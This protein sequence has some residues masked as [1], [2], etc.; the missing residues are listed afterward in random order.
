MNSVT[1]RNKLK[2]ESDSQTSSYRTSNNKYNAIKLEYNR[3][4]VSTS[5]INTTFS[6]PKKST[7]KQEY[8]TQSSASDSL[9]RKYNVTQPK[10][11]HYTSSIRS[12]N[13][14]TTVS[15]PG[16]ITNNNVYSYYQGNSKLLFGISSALILFFIFTVFLLA[17][18]FHKKKR[19][20]NNDKKRIHD[21]SNRNNR[22][23]LDELGELVDVISRRQTEKVTTDDVIKVVQGEKFYLASLPISCDVRCNEAVKTENKILVN[24]IPDVKQVI[25]HVTSAASSHDDRAENNLE[26]MT[27]LPTSCDVHNSDV[28]VMESPSKSL[29]KSSTRSLVVDDSSFWIHVSDLM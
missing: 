22:I 7:K 14:N 28:S 27:S 1:N 13:T 6:K 21:N 17:Y 9:S 4:F 18:I 29:D 26:I 15:K 8:T 25:N 23:S 10:K 16:S 5:S 24:E 12:S 3:I 19:R 20:K 2:Q 11:K